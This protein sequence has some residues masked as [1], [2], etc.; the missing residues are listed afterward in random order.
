MNIK[1][2]K[3]NGKRFMKLLPI[4]SF[5]YIPEKE[6]SLII[7]LRSITSFFLSTKKI[8]PFEDIFLEPQKEC[9]QKLFEIKRSDKGDL[10]YIE[11]PRSFRFFFKKENQSWTKEKWMLWVRECI[12]L[13]TYF[14]HI[15]KKIQLFYQKEILTSIEISSIQMKYINEKVEG[16][17]ISMIQSFFEYQYRLEETNIKKLNKIDWNSMLGGHVDA[18]KILFRQFSSIEKRNKIVSNIFKIV[19]LLYPF[20]E[21][22]C[23]NLKKVDTL[24]LDF[25]KEVNKVIQNEVSFIETKKIDFRNWFFSL[26]QFFLYCK[27]IEFNIEESICRFNLIF[28]L[29]FHEDEMEKTLNISYINDSS[30][31]HLTNEKKDKLLEIHPFMRNVYFSNYL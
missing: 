17:D 16:F 31:R 29:T 1:K 19:T 15:Q 9:L 12:Q 13:L 4:Y 8:V 25:K 27:P 30:I 11:H 18:M 6:S 21:K 14:P 5:F 26:S 7:S 22:N 10:F 20:L 23:K 28:Y 2:K 24:V 3:N